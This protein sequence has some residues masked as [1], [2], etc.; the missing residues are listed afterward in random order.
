MK[1][2][3]LALAISALAL[4]SNVQAIPL[5]IG[6][7]PLDGTTVEDD[8]QL[9]G[10]IIAD[11]TVAFNFAAYGGTVSGFVQSRVVR[12][13][14][15]GTLDF[16]WRVIND[17]S[18]AGAITSFRLDNFVVPVYDG[19]YRIDGLGEVAPDSALRFPGPAVNFLFG[20]L[21]GSTLGPGASS[22]FMFL[23]TTAR[24]FNRS[25]R[26]D[27]TTLENGSISRLFSTFAPAQVPEPATYALFASGMLFLTLTRRRRH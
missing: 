18:S 19:D 17:E 4:G 2:L 10:T 12:S 16:Y 24:T 20:N 6:T 3:T 15:D 9:A 27:M 5:P 23:D 7:T 13:D 25:A 8:P 21:S 22:N 26:Y 14:V 1:R 11:E